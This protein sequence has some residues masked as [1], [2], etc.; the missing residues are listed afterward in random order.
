MFLSKELSNATTRW[1]SIG[2]EEAEEALR[3]RGG[4]EEAELQTVIFKTH[5]HWLLA[6]RQ[7]RSIPRFCSDQEET[8]ELE[9][10]KLSVAQ[11]L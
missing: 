5:R 9:H 10:S 11:D 3:L 7:A 2:S 6:H 4:S 1:V 8:L